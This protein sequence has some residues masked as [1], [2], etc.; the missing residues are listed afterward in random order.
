[1]WKHSE[2]KRKKNYSSSVSAVFTPALPADYH[3]KFNRSAILMKKAEF[4]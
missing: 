3:K 1:M 4:G 2:S